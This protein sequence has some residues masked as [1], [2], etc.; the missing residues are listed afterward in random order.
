MLKEILNSIEE[1]YNTKKEEINKLNNL[2]DITDT[3]KNLWETP[4][5]TNTAPE[6]KINIITEIC[7]DINKEKAITIANLIPYAETYL[8]IFYIKELKTDIEYSLIL[9]NN[10]MWI[11]NNKQYGAFPYTNLKTTII[12]NNLMSKIIL[13]NNILIE[14]N[15]NNTKIN[16]LINIINDTNYRIKTIT[17]KTQYLKGIIPTYQ[18]INEIQSGISLDNNQNIVFH[19]KEKN[20]RYKTN[21]IDNYEILLDNTVYMSKLKNTSKT[22]GSFQNTCYQINIRITIKDNTIINIPILPQNT[23]GTKY[24][25]HDSTFIKK[26]DFATKIMNI[27]NEITK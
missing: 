16:N 21:D 14:V 5:K 25:N 8:D 4:I 18:L 27:L 1:K 13:L 20:Y 26:L 2:L 17:T 22:I 10:Y 6:Y 9:T 3:F 12:K 7:P 19:T 23:F 11:I 24:N 15:G